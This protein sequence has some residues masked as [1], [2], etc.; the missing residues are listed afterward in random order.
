[1]TEHDR[2]LMEL[3]DLL[4]A[5]SDRL[6]RAKLLATELKGRMIQSWVLSKIPGDIHS[7][8]AT[9][10]NSLYLLKREI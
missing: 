4:T 5:V 3:R 6:G 8:Q 2:D 10:E 1:M 7:A 9:I